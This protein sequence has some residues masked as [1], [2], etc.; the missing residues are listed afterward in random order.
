MKDRWA[1]PALLR[2]P[3]LRVRGAAVVDGLGRVDR[4]GPE[5]DRADTVLN[6]DADGLRLLRPRAGVADHVVLEDQA[7]GLAADADG[8]GARLP[9]V[10]LDDVVLQAVAVGRHAAQLVAEEHAV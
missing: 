5:L 1:M 9:A 3:R 10:V 6:Q 4:V 8:G 2:R 7:G